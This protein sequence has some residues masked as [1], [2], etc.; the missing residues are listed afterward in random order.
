FFRP[1]GA[2]LLV[3]VLACNFVA[4]A[5][6][7]ET[8]AASRATEPV[9]AFHVDVKETVEFLASDDL[10][11]RGVG[12]AG[13]DKAAERV[14]D[15]FQKLGLK[16][17]PGFNDYFQPFTMTT[18]VSPDPKTSLALDDKKYTIGTEF[19][20]A[21]FSGEGKFDAPAIFVGYGITSKENNYD[22]YD[23]LDV[24][25]KVVVALRFEPHNSAGT[26][27]FN[28]EDWSKEAHLTRKAKVASEHGA[29][30]L[31]LVNP[32][33][34]HVGDMLMSFGSQF[35][36]EKSSIPVIQV[37][38]SVADAWLQQGT[39]KTLKALQEEIDKDGK[40][41]SAGLEGVKLAGAV[42]IH[43]EE[44]Q[45]KNVV[46][47]LPG[48]GEH[49]DEYVVIG[50][51]YDHLGW[52]GFG[53]LSPGTHAIHHGADDNASGTSTMLALADHF[54][55]AGPQAR[56]IVFIAFT[57]EEEGL[58]GSQH[59]VSHPPIPLE[60]VA[61]MLNLDMVG[62][63]RNNLLYVGGGGTAPGFDAIL[64]EANVGSP[65]VLKTFGRGGYGPSDHMSFA[66][67]KVP[68]MFLFSGMHMDYHRPT[69]TAEKVNFDGM[70][71]VAAFATKIANSM[72][73]MPREKYVDAAD[74]TGGMMAA[75]HGTGSSVTLGV[76]PDYSETD[77]T[78][79]V[80]ITGTVPGSPAE[81]AGLKDGDVLVRF[82]KDK[83]DTLYDLTDSLSR[84][85]P[86]DMVKLGVVRD[87]QTV[88]LDAT[89]VER[90]G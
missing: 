3:A 19:N 87:K 62:R 81:K 74:T 57:A 25:G 5:A 59:F 10:E 41:A 49:A 35:P 86:G 17:V 79:G 40:P 37:R 83:I 2:S 7:V 9:S 78:K 67:K 55:H 46:A 65:L 8:P 28:K 1:A 60:K 36:G 6:K 29:A 72:V 63:V 12:T 75:G 61:A 56:T 90:K 48:K 32:P 71:D 44:K 4:G 11:G 89:L 80:R 82:G 77:T 43:R 31:V 66:Q 58:I 13:L 18:S 52:G 34:Y 84:A 26:S 47:V 15:D 16:P 42:V 45:V 33:T 73:A 27:R 23:G 88:E 68:V 39:H 53:S 22:D 76:V 21:S 38:Q 85:K 14:A 69:D 51:H 20:P 54:A 24:K 30:A 64:K 70:K 50:S